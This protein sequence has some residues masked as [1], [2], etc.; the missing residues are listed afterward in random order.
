M[1]HGLKITKRDGCLNAENSALPLKRTPKQLDCVSSGVQGGCVD[2]LVLA[3][4][5]VVVVVAG[6]AIAR[7]LSL[8]A[9]QGPARG[10][11]VHPSGQDTSAPAA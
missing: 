3:S 4:P 9:R 7:R 5:V 6:V 8:R 11:D 10:R 1:R 2:A